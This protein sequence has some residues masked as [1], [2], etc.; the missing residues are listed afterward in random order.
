LRTGRQH[1]VVIEYNEVDGLLPTLIKYDLW[2][3][4]PVSPDVAF[5]IPVLNLI[6]SLVLECQA[7]VMKVLDALQLLSATLFPMPQKVT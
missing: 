2:P 7:A 1:E 4:S 3:A 5:H 6:K